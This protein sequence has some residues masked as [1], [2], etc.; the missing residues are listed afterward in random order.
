MAI[1]LG[2]LTVMNAAILWFVIETQ[3]VMVEQNKA[4]AS[5]LSELSRRVVG[6]GNA[7]DPGRD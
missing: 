2:V 6:T 5:L 3:W 4:L 7:G 1:W